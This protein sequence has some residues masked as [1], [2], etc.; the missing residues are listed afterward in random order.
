MQG[1]A[2]PLDAASRGAFDARLREISERIPTGTLGLSAFDY[3]SGLSWSFNGD[4][5][6]HAASVIKVAL[7]VALFDAVEQ[8]RFSL[9]SRLH[10]RN[11]FLSIADGRPYRIDPARDADA[12]VH[13]AVGRTMTVQQLARRMIVTSSNLATNL[14][15]NLVGLDAARASLARLEI[16]GVDI[17]RGVEDDRAFDLGVSN[18]MTPNG[19]IALLRTIVAAKG[20]SPESADAMTSILFEQQFGGTIA[21]GIP[22]TIR[23]IAKIA[24]KTGEISTATHD[25]GAVFMPGRPPYLVAVFVETSGEAKDRQDAGVA[26][27]AAVYECVSA[28]GEG[29][30]R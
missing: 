14:L 11:R 3:L 4:R 25:A 17:C 1:T 7:L 26:A 16:D 9:R 6:F 27:S 30:P 8:G 10:V 19:A 15:V 22:E 13:A 12:E 24:H 29:V 5:W 28:A 18:R 20:I 2:D 21:P 23:G